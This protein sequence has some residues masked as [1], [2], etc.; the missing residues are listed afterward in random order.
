M[1]KI[2]EFCF[3]EKQSPAYYLFINDL[4]RDV[5]LDYEDFFRDEFDVLR[6]LFP[7]RYINDKKYVE[8]YISNLRNKLTDGYTHTLKSLDEYVIAKILLDVA[9]VAD[10]DEICPGFKTYLAELIQQKKYNTLTDIEVKK[11]KEMCRLLDKCSNLDFVRDYLIREIFLDDDLWC[12]EL[13]CIYEVYKQ[14][15]ELFQEFI[16]FNN[17]DYFMDIMPQDIQDEYLEIRDKREDTKAKKIEEPITKEKF[18]EIVI[19]SID[20]FKFDIEKMRGYHL[21]NNKH[22]GK[23]SEQEIQILFNLLLTDEMKKYGVTIIRE[24][25]TGKGKVDFQFVLNSDIQAL[26][27]IKLFSNSN[28][29]QGLEYQLPTYLSSS[30]IDFGVYLLICYNQKEKVRSME[31]IRW[32]E[33]VSL[34]QQKD[35]RFYS[36]MIPEQVLTG[37]K[38]KSS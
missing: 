9:V 6:Q 20:K 33:E 18:K 26:M 8:Q 15:N 37:S 30:K 24:P 34:K 16:G 23:A 13:N 17:M 5:V 21:L 3:F 11:I 38:I 31:Y 22:R 19:R 14:S 1:I 35:I 10:D 2:I 36:I 4:V 12:F 7:P 28:K 32:A 29:K 27:E 25:E